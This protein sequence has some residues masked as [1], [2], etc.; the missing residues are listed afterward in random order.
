MLYVLQPPP[1]AAAATPDTTTTTTS[2]SASDDV[3]DLQ[4]LPMTVR[5]GTFLLDGLEHVHDGLRRID[6]PLHVI[7]STSNDQVGSTVYDVAIKQYHARAVVCDMNP[8]R[9]YRAW[10]EDQF[11]PTM[12]Q[13]Q[14]PATAVP[15][16]QV[17]AHNVVPVWVAS[18]KREYGAR[19]IRT[20]IHKVVGEYTQHPY[21]VLDGMIR[22]QQQ[23]QYDELVLP[24]AFDRTQYEE[25]MQLDTTVP[26][27]DWAKGNTE[28]GYGRFRD[29][30][31]QGLSKFDTLRNDPNQ[32]RT[33]CSQ[34]SPW[35]N[36]G[37]ISFQRLLTEVQTINKFANG[38]AAFVEE[39]L[40]RRELSD[41]MCFYAPTTYDTIEV[42]YD[43]AQ[44]TLRDH[45]D[46]E[47][48]YV[49]TLDEFEHGSTHDDLW[50]AAQLQA[51]R[52][53]KMHGFL[54]MYWAKKILEWT[55]KPEI[56]LAY[57]Q[58]LNDKFN[59]DGRDPNGFVGVAWSMIGIHDQGWAERKIFG[60]IRY[61][62]YDGCR[63]K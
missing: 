59:L 24:S 9:Q 2:K 33:V 47:R 56:A 46:D 6:V 10:I 43:W 25:Y 62:N 23:K 7:M 32:D 26:T 28:N 1:P 27:L 54:R 20:K 5:H 3:P 36:H 11:I 41:N 39:G 4:N 22:S 51:V 14:D 35:L 48:Q 29:F 16:Y 40:I 49:Y 17:D 63:R 19:T 34:L 52:E 8:L 18:T 55:P 50:N 53:G 31:T 37:H 21:P 30:L 60:K 57:G 45:A 61:M 42:G 15:V 58:Y 44:G 38:T 12:Q 13:Q